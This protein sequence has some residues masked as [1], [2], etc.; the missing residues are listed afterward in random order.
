[1]KQKLLLAF[2]LIITNVIS[3]QIINNFEQGNQSITSQNVAFRNQIGSGFS[4]N[5]CN[6]APVFGNVL[7]PSTFINNTSVKAVLVTPGLEPV[8]QS[9]G[10]T[11]NRVGPN[12]GNFSLRLN[13]TISND[14]DRTSF[15]QK[16][17]TNSLFANQKFITFDFFA[18]LNSSHIYNLSKQPFFTVR[19]LDENDNIITAIPQWCIIADPNE[20]NLIGNGTNLFYTNGWFCKTIEIPR[21]YLNRELKL[22]FV[23]TD[24]GDGG[25]I[26]VVYIDNIR[27]GDNCD[28]PFESPEPIFDLN[29]ISLGCG[30]HNLSVS[31]LFDVSNQLQPNNLEVELYK[32]NISIPYNISALTV[33]NFANGNFN[34]D[35][36]LNA[37]DIPFGDYKIIVTGN[38][39]TNTN[40]TVTYQTQT[41]PGIV[42]FTYFVI[43]DFN[44]TIEPDNHIHWT[45]F[46][47]PYTIEVSTD[48]TCC[49]GHLD[50]YEAPNIQ[51]IVSPDNKEFM[52]D[53]LMIAGNKCFR[54][55]IQTPCGWTEWCCLTSY[56][57]GTG[58]PL[59]ENIGNNLNIECVIDLN[60]LALKPLVSPNP[61][62]S[63]ITIVNSNSTI[64]DIYD[65][66]QNKVKTIKTVKVEE[67]VNI[68]L[69][70]LKSGI[71]I[72][73]LNNNQDI[74]I[75]KQ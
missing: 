48:N 31:G 65:L 63:I 35:I 25:H 56:P 29:T 26:G 75:I 16:F 62:T 37:A 69:S 49:P 24:C 19:V 74:K 55:R 53:M 20:P 43:D 23:I 46:G 41:S 71:Y 60:Y 21:L 32:N 15:T 11:E 68:D 33:T 3:A 4:I 10:I 61:T 5:F 40:G 22:Q 73:K 72:L 50:Y 17:S 47:G 39:L 64:F 7:I 30:E 18:I 36:D 66:S 67:K 42:D 34:F 12:G 45:D 28:N 1:M 6:I 8:L 54:Y 51:Q 57:F 52:I 70:D 58:Y 9:H 38:F 59:G 14:Y 44:V 27:F 13:N 2:L